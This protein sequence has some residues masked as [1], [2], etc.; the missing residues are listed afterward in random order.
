MKEMTIRALMQ[1]RIGIRGRMAEM[2]NA[3]TNITPLR[4]DLGANGLCIFI[5]SVSAPALFF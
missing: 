3:L 1:I 4:Y 5:V 2:N